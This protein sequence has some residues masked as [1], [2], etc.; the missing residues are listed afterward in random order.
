M[1]FKVINKPYLEFQE[2]LKNIKQIK[3]NRKIYF[4]NKVKNII[5]AY[6]ISNRTMRNAFINHLNLLILM[7]KKLKYRLLRD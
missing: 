5:L 6:Y 1:N 2:E 7:M 4:N 3:K